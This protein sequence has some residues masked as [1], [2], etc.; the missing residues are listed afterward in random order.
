[1]LNEWL[2]NPA[3]LNVIGIG[4]LV[5][6]VAAVATYVWGQA[7]RARAAAKQPAADRF[8]PYLA[9]IALIGAGIYMVFS[10][11]VDETPK[12]TVTKLGGC[13]LG[14]S[15]PAQ[16]RTTS[17]IVVDATVR[18][19]NARSL[20]TSVPCTN[21]LRSAALMVDGQLAR[22]EFPIVIE[23]KKTTHR[24]FP[25]ALTAGKHRIDV[26]SKSLLGSYTAAALV[27]NADMKFLGKKDGFAISGC[28]THFLYPGGSST[29]GQSVSID[30]K[31]TCGKPKDVAPMLFVNG[32]ALKPLAS[33]DDSNGTQAF[34]WVFTRTKNP[35]RLDAVVVDVADDWTTAIVARQPVT[36]NNLK[37]SLSA[38]AGV[39]VALSGL[40]V[41]V[42]QYVRGQSPNL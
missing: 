8:S 18:D 17:G 22:D 15:A 11:W 3:V 27:T 13:D 4:S 29:M 28:T 23:E 24:W 42:T 2:T 31:V 26:I 25:A 16:I 21:V 35:D 14:F 33:N 7:T 32:V 5:L 19:E 1:M 12:L 20:T 34:R 9:G 10:N 41:T 40:L 38:I 6:L 30:I 36:L 39:V 37:E